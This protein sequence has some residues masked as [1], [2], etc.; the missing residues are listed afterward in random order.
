MPG[1]VVTAG[2]EVTQILAGLPPFAYGQQVV[3]LDVFQWHC[4]LIPDLFP[5]HTASR[6]RDAS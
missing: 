4:S 3:G 6:H 2:H 1:G 5:N